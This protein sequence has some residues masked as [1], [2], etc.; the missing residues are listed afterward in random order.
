MMRNTS[1]LAILAVALGPAILAGCHS[2]TQ[3]TSTTTST[4]K[5]DETHASSLTVRREADTADDYIARVQGAKT[6]IDEAEALRQ[7]RQY[8]TEHGLTYT[9]RTFRAIDNTEV[10]S[11]SLASQPVRAQVTVYRGREPL[12]TFNFI[13]KDNRNLTILGE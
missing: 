7:L 2:S 3:T 13:P 8:E 1:L 9:V 12:R 11:S 4:T 6:A 10:P 5:I